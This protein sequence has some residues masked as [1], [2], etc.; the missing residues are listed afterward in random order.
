[1]T[2]PSERSRSVKQT[3]EFLQELVRNPC[4][5]EEIKREAKRLLRHYPSAEDVLRVGQLE[6]YL[7]SEQHDDKAR[8]LF[9]AIYHPRFGSGGDSGS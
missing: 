2:L 7:F 3:G 8:D 4:M 9:M 1:M 5:P 6:D